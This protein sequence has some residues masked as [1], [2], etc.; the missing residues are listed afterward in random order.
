MK[1][2]L[3]LLALMF[4]HKIESSKFNLKLRPFDTSLEKENQYKYPVS[5][6]RKQCIRMD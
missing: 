3:L 6:I 5:F 4:T 2:L 1:L